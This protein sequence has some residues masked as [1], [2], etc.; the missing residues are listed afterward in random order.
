M[1]TSTTLPQLNFEMVYPAV[2]LLSTS[3]YLNNV[4]ILANNYSTIIVVL[5][6]LYG[7]LCTVKCC[8]AFYWIPTSFLNQ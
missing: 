6:T 1:L 2:L 8:T 3:T 7:G 5:Y 4:L